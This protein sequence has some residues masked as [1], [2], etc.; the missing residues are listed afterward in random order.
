MT[1]YCQWFDERKGYGF[2][3]GDDGLKYFVLGSEVLGRPLSTGARVSFDATSPKGL[4]A[5]GVRRLEP[6][7]SSRT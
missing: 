3:Q 2:V 4:R 7:G 5:V 6:A 1:G